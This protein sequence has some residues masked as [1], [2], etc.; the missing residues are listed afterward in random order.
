MQNGKD[1]NP[2]L[3][4]WSVSISSPTH[5]AVYYGKLVDV[6]TTPVE[7]WCVVHHPNNK[8]MTASW[9]MPIY[10]SPAWCAGQAAIQTKDRDYDNGWTASNSEA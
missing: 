8:A 7:H 2:D 10:R 1:K 5:S 6:Y 3:T 9:R 4:Q